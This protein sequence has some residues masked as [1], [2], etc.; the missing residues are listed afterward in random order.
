MQRMPILVKLAPQMGA[1][2]VS[3]AP[4]KALEGKHDEVPHGKGLQ[5]SKI[6]KVAG[7][8]GCP[9]RSTIVRLRLRERCHLPRGNDP[10][11]ARWGGPVLVAEIVPARR[12]ACQGGGRIQT[13]QR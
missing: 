10:M 11:R 12:G 2:Y 7:C 1:D 4:R 6:L 3:S 9:R 8:A 5:T 13:L